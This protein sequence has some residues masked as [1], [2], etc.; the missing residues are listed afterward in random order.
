MTTQ[1]RRL[2]IVEQFALRSLVFVVVMAVLLGVTLSV[3]VRTLF[4]GEAAKTGQMTTTAIV[5]HHVAG[6]DLRARTLPASLIAVL[7][8]MAN[9]DLGAAG[10]TTIKLWNSEGVLL[11]SSDGQKIGQSFADHPPFVAALAGQTEVEVAKEADAENE[12]QFARDGR[13]IEVYSPL[14]IDGRTVGV[15][16]IYQRYA[17]V[18]SVLNRFLALM[19]LVILGGSVPAYF[20]QLR[21]VRHTAHQLLAAQGDLAEV[22]QRLTSSLEDME[23]HSL[24]TL[25]ALVAAV[26]AKDSYTARHSI[27]VTDHAVA[28][29]RRMNLSAETIADVERA[30]LLHDIGKIGTPEMILLKPD[31]LTQGEFSVIAEHSEA[32]GHIVESV[33]FL[34]HLMP[35]IRSH[36]ERWDG[37]GY[38]DGL[39]GESIPALAR[40]LTVADAFDA[41]ISE[42]PYRKPMSLEAARAEVV[43]CAGTQFDPAVVAALLE[44]LDHGEIRVVDHTESARTR[45]RKALSRT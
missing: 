18:A 16:E 43:R 3:A 34:A 17:P 22:N 41:M 1:P 36:H 40:I 7:D 4:I 45:R 8:D 42:R 31:R 29:A 9:E 15:F 13:V 11:Y 19:W 5:A 28:I 26:D 33:P 44:A 21:L 37:A 30:G 6:I 39:A 10:I 2:G 20:L 32:G 23:L 38:P 12:A 24:G 25:Q 14:I 35:V 27:S